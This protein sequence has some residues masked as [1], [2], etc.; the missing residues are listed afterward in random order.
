VAGGL[1]RLPTSLA[2]LLAAAI[3]AVT[4]AWIAEAL[5]R[6]PRVPPGPAR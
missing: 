3:L 1:T 2:I 6:Q 5:L 4:I